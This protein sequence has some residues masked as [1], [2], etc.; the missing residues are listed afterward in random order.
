MGHDPR[1]Y[2]KSTSDGSSR[3]RISWS[4]EGCNTFCHRVPTNI[5]RENE[6]INPQTKARHGISIS[7]HQ[8]PQCTHLRD[9]IFIMN[10]FTTAIALILASVVYGA[11]APNE[12]IVERVLPGGG[13]S[14]ANGCASGL[15]K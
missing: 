8:Q 14:R 10:F 9:I 11:P 2:R 12:D 7:P 3:G 5:E 15:K 6:Y 4:S 1:G 13:C